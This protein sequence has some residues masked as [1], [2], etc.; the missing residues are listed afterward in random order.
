MP[1][2]NLSQ[3]PTDQMQQSPNQVRLHTGRLVLTPVDPQVAAAHE[4]VIAT[5]RDLGL[6]GP[7]LPHREGFAVGPKFLDLIAFT[8]CAV[9]LNLEPP[10]SGAAFCHI[11]IPPPAPSPRLLSGRNTRPPQCPACRRPLRQWRDQA[12]HWDQASIP[13]LHC[14]DC[15]EQ[16]QAWAWRWREQAGFGRAFVLIEEVFP[17][18]GTPLPGLMRGLETIGAGPWHRFYVQD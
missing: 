3:T 5:A 1:C 13:L 11:R 10:T 4:R 8:G 7:A 12:A 16:T 15:G 2:A 9:Q 14:V 6:I 17:G 18:E